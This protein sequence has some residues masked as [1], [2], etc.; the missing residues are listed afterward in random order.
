MNTTFKTI[1][2]FIGLRD[3]PI[4]DFGVKGRPPLFDDD[5]DDNY[6]GFR[7]RQEDRKTIT[8]DPSLRRS[9]P[10]NRTTYGDRDV[11]RSRF[12]TSISDGTKGQPNRGSAPF[13]R[14][15]FD[16]N[17]D[18]QDIDRDT[19]VRR[20]TKVFITNGPILTNDDKRIP[21]KDDRSYGP[22]QQHI[23]F[24]DKSLKDDRFEKDQRFGGPQRPSDGSRPQRPLQR[25]PKPEREQD[26]RPY[27]TGRDPNQGLFFSRFK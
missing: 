25:E 27:S 5:R 9:R 11:N 2:L 4:R 26:G 21:P 13:N 3:K 22:E 23:D 19:R 10:T 24:D 18:K 17:K 12:D 8:D 15:S 1:S 16:V 6:D 20:P 7:R 14:S